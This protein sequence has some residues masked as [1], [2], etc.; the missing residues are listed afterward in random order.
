MLWL[1]IILWLLMLLVLP[2]IAYLFVLTAA[3]SMRPRSKNGDRTFN[4]ALA[5]IVPAHNERGGIETTLRNLKAIAD[6]DGATD[7]FVIADNCT[8]DTASLARCCG[9]TVLERKDTERRGKGF[10]LQYAFENLADAGYEAY[11]IVDADSVT[12]TNFLSAVRAELAA[13]A[14]AV[15]VKYTVLGADQTPRM[16]LADLALTAFNVLRP[17]GRDRLGLSAGIFGNG[18]ALH[19]QALAVVP[20]CAGSVVEDLE[21]HIALVQAGIRVSFI[22]DTCVRAAMPTGSTGSRVQRARWEGGRLRMIRQSVP[23][24]LVHVLHGRWRLLDPLLELLTP[25]LA[26]FVTTLGA[27]L[28]A[29]LFAGP[30]TVTVISAIGL[31]TLSWHVVLSCKLAQF[32]K[33]DYWVLLQVP[34]YLLWKLRMLPSI[35]AGSKRDSEWVRTNREGK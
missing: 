17:T 14:Q 16:K 11:I 5:V 18:F 28:S 13:G 21:Y 4:A 15:Q 3:A 7:I 25:P 31:L 34:G 29:S 22:S 35:V 30:T 2:A 12:D 1:E 10:A 8:D 32:G 19:R 27:L 23:L 24:L 20:Y 6:T 33:D 9:A 26:F